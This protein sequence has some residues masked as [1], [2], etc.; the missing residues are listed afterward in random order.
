MNNEVKRAAIDK[1]N[2]NKWVLLEVSV[3]TDTQKT[4]SISLLYIINTDVPNYN[5][6]S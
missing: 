3:K 2:E 1:I 6:F 4:G 5:V